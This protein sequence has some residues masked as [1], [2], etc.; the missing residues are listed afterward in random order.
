MQKQSQNLWFNVGYRSISKEQST[1]TC[2]WPWVIQSAF[3][4]SVKI[5]KE[6][7]T[8]APWRQEGDSPSKLSEKVSMRNRN[9]NITHQ[10][11]THPREWKQ[12]SQEALNETVAYSKYYDWAVCFLFVF[13]FIYLYF[14][15]LQYHIKESTSSFNVQRK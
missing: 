5:V 8:W 6:A 4:N 1:L 12:S 9:V 11:K 7:L 3:Q 2:K 13:N 10:K 14:H 15:L